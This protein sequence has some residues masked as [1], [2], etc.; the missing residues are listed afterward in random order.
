MR[1]T[2]KPGAPEAGRLI[3]LHVDIA[4]SREVPDPTY[5]DL[6]PAA[7]LEMAVALS[8]PGGKA[9]YFLRPLA[10]VGTYGLHWTPQAKGLWTVSLAPLVAGLVGPELK[11]ELG[12]GVPMPVSSQGQAVQ[13]SRQVLGAP[14][15]ARE[16]PKLALLMREVWTRWA[17]LSDPAG[18]AAAEGAALVKLFQSSQGKVP[19]AWVAAGTEFDA[20][21]A[22]AAK[23]IEQA[24]ALPKAERHKRLEQLE[25]ESCL[26]CHVKFRDGVVAD[27]SG[28]PEVSPWRK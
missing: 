28:W 24:V 3:E 16:T 4:R 17:R 9:R 6:V 14:K 19:Q 20:Q 26:K 7:K 11:F 2:I 1:V 5:G 22:E 27:V 10:D 15:T 8:G 21:A 12:V 25:V 13:S 23:R 18:D